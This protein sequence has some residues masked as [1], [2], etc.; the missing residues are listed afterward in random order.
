[1]D[2]EELAIPLSDGP[3]SLPNLVPQI[4]SAELILDNAAD[5][6]RDPPTVRH[7]QRS[8]YWNKWLMA[9]HEELKV[10]KAKEVYEEVS[11]LPLGRKAVQCKWVLRIKR[12]KD[13]Q[14]S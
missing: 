7:A 8:K 4:L 11:E 14:I 3:L 5:D 12:D 1:M 9:M 2:D 13:S 6:E 10:L